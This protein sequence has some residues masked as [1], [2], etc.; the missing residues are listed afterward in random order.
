MNQTEKLERLYRELSKALG[1]PNDVSFEGRSSR[2]AERSR[3]VPDEI[4]G[5]IAVIA[6]SHGDTSLDGGYINMAE[7]GEH[8]LADETITVYEST[9]TF[10][11]ATDEEIVKSLPMRIREALERFYELQEGVGVKWFMRDWCLPSGG[12]ESLLTT[13][14][15]TTTMVSF[16]IHQRGVAIQARDG[17][18]VID[19]DEY[20]PQ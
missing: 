8:N 2:Q 20:H 17:L 15:R 18:F 9:T 3:N 12:F 19:A 6:F 7:Y 1:N 13:V 11:V 4:K 14:L 10:P 16:L 5:M